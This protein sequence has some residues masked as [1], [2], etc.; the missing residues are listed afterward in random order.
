MLSGDR[1]IPIAVIF[2]PVS[3][4]VGKCDRPLRNGEIEKIDEHNNCHER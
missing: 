3:K 4:I 1:A 2:Y